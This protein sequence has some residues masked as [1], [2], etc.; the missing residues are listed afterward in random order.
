MTKW[1]RL[2]VPKSEGP[3]AVA[4]GA[5]YCKE[6]RGSTT[7]LWT[8]LERSSFPAWIRERLTLPAAEVL[9]LPYEMREQAKA[10]GAHWDAD[11]HAWKMPQGVKPPQS[12]MQYVVV[13]GG[14]V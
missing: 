12:L 6:T 5:E 8:P 14:P 9:R 3:L 11:R 13:A 10:A 1:H 2:H 4:L 7:P